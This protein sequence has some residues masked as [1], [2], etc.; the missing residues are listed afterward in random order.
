MEG[1]AAE[2]YPNIDNLGSQEEKY[3]FNS[4]TSGDNKQDTC[5]SYAHMVHLF[6][7]YVELGLLVSDVSNV[8]EETDGCAKQYRRNLAT[9][10][11]NM[12]SYL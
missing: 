11:L 6:K 1:I 8:W 3:E 4:Y 5:D 2:Y 12:L 7:R 10:L 9:Y